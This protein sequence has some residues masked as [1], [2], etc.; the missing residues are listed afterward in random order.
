MLNIGVDPVSGWPLV[1]VLNQ[2]HPD[3]HLAWDGPN[4]GRVTVVK[5]PSC[6][7]LVENTDSLMHG[8]ACSG[9]K[10]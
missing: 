4:Q 5:C 8:M 6:R 3:G 2:V 9:V 1:T 7:A 10:R